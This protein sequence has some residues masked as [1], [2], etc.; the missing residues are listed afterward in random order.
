MTMQW[1]S[2]RLLSRQ[3][4]RY[5]FLP[6]HNGCGVKTAKSA[7]KMQLPLNRYS[8]CNSKR[9]WEF[10]ARRRLQIPSITSR[11]EGDGHIA[12][13]RCLKISNGFHQYISKH[14]RSCPIASKTKPRHSDRR[15]NS[16]PAPWINRAITHHHG[17]LRGNNCRTWDSESLHVR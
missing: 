5:G 16:H 1:L 4:R 10:S 6:P 12:K 13:P 17:R 8:R 2:S 3:Y 11:L 15:I 7:E 14:E 9:W